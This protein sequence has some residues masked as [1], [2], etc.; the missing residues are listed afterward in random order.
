MKGEGMFE[1]GRARGHVSVY[2][3]HRYEGRRAEPHSVLS[4]GISWTLSQVLMLLMQAHVSRGHNP[5]RTKTLKART[6]QWAT[7]VI[8]VTNQSIAVLG[9]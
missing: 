5:L 4:S 9:S 1:V 7:T 8:R 2:I 3:S 6:D